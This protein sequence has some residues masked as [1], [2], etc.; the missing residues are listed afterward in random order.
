MPYQFTR[1]RKS[2]EAESTLVALLLD[3]I[4]TRR[5]GKL[6]LDFDGITEVVFFFGR[7]IHLINNALWA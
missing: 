1:R 2:L 5:N 7:D 6:V 3:T 4:R